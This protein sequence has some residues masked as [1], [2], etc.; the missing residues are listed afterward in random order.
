MKQTV[1]TISIA[2]A[3]ITLS[4]WPDLLALG[5]DDSDLALKLQNPVADLISVP[6]QNNWDFGIGPANAMRYTGNVQPVIPFSLTRDYNLISRTIVPFIYAESPTSG[7]RDAWGIGD[8]LQSFFVSP[9]RKYNGWIL[10]AGCAELIPTSTDSLL[11]SGE[12]AV[13][14]TAVALQ[15]R[16]GWTYGGLMYHIWSVAGW[17]E[18]VNLTYLQPFVSYTTRQLTTFTIN[19]ETT[20]DWH[21]DDWTIPFNFM[22]AQLLR[23]GNQPVQLQAG[24]RVYAES[25]NNGPDWGFRLSI[26]FLFPR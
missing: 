11:G 1:R 4:T 19:T 5:S 16:D 24:F 23:L 3:L 8:T 14:P 21:H 15:Q 18:S 17:G 7:G 2:T 13:G 6:I 10:G 26:T 25:P 9:I 22:A 12:W 20:Y